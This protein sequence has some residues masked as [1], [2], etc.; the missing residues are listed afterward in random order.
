MAGFELD[1]FDSIAPRNNALLVGHDAAE[2]EFLASVESG[3]LH[4]AWLICGPRGIGK[5]TLAYRMARHVLARPSAAQAKVGLG[6]FGDDLPDAGLSAGSLCFDPGHPVFRRIAAGGHSDFLAVE[7]SV[8]ENTKKRRSEIVVG[9]VRAIASFL[10]MTPGEGDWRVVIIDAAD[11]MNGN[12]ANAVL[13][14]L[15][16]P[17]QQALILLVAHN[18]SRLLPTVR[19]RCRS[20]VLQP[21]RDPSITDLLMRYAPDVSADD[22]ARLAALADGSIGQAL[23]FARNGGLEIYD[24]ANELFAH[25]PELD[26]RALHKLGDKMARDRSGEEFRT[27]GIILLRWLADSAKSAVKSGAGTARWA[28]LWSETNGLFRKAESV[29]LDRKQITLNAFLAIQTAA[30]NGR[31]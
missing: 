12:A 9:D 11:E 23:V 19:S 30:Q 4:H 13:K 17:P 25:L 14:V 18:P 1:E 15:E 21:L 27:L 20:L 6:L 10:S 7:R 2:A 22:L 24:A 28:E 5:A 16:E 29:N 3:Q 8:D 31:I 26:I